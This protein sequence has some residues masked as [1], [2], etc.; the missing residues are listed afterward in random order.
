MAL[1]SARSPKLR[2]ALRKAKDDGLH[3]LVLD[4]TLIACDR[5]RSDRP[6]YSAKHRCH[7][8]GERQIND[9]EAG[10]PWWRNVL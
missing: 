7:G 9:Q 1:L 5:V 10:Y 8:R 2:A 6:Y 3:L 4:G